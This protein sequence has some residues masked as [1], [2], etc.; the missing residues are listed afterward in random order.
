MHYLYSK[1]YLNMFKKINLLLFIFIIISC[2]QAFENQLTNTKPRLLAPAN[3]L[4][5]SDTLHT[6]YWETVPGAV[7][8]QLQVVTPTFESIARLIT[9]TII[10]HNKITLTLR[11]S[12]YQWRIK[13]LN[14]STSSNYSDTFRLKIQ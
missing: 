9:D 11:K 4:I 7:E 14:I 3:N 13:A 2:E 12:D 6:F 8:Y 10:T 1:H 5:T